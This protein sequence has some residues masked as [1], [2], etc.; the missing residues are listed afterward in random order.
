MTVPMQLRLFWRSAFIQALWSFENMQGLGFGFT[1]EPW[2]RER[3]RNAPEEGRRALARHCEHFNTQPYMA[4]FA[5]GMACA[6][7]EQLAASS[8]DARPGLEGRLRALKSGAAGALAGIG[9]SF[10]WGA[11]RPFCTALALAA[12]LA[13]VV[14]GARPGTVILGAAGCYLLAYAVPVLALRWLGIGLGY[15]WGELFAQ[16]LS[17]VRWQRSIRVVRVAGLGLALGCAGV[18][19]FSI[20]SSVSLSRGA[21]VAAALAGGWAARSYGLT[22]R[23][24]YAA[25]WL[26]G[27]L[28]AMAGLRW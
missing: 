28:A 27:T 21:V 5:A 18:G 22:S 12:G 19:I 4:G 1:V 11:W 26:S 14:F 9:D 2:L 23:R 17:R 24:L 10:F 6:M 20:M 13:C 7:E 15:R 8:R 25:V 16:E 3:W